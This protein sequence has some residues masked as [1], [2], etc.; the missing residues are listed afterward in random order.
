MSTEKIIIQ[1]DK[2]DKL[3]NVNGSHNIEKLLKEYIKKELP[4]GNEPYHHETEVVAGIKYFIEWLKPK[5][6]LLNNTKETILRDIFD[7]IIGTILEKLDTPIESYTEEQM[8]DLF[9]SFKRIKLFPIPDDYYDSI[10]DNERKE[11]G[12]LLIENNDISSSDI[13]SNMSVG[14]IIW[15]LSNWDKREMYNTLH[16]E[17]GEDY[18]DR[19]YSKYELVVDDH[20]STVYDEILAKQ[21][22]SIHKNRIKLS[23][24]EELFIENLAKRL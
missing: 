20:N 6:Q 4:N 21:L 22:L 9:G 14:D 10:D 11:L 19:E 3:V 2:R 13:I 24:E 23:S 12:E 16:D 15:E 8:N 18:E 7:E 17:Y 1:R 5:E